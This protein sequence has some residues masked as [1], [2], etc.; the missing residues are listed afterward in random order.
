MPPRSPEFNVL[1]YSLW[2]AIN[3][4]M[5]AQERKFPAKK[6]ESKTGF[7]ARLRRT[8][9]GLPQRVVEKAVMG[10]HR[11]VRR[12]VAAKGGIFFG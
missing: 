7:L 12:C 6:K 11:R 3:A 10:M 1:D 8:A 5:R 2:H 4:R 9:L